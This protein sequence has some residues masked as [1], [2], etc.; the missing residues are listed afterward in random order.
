MKV[1]ISMCIYVYENSKWGLQHHFIVVRTVLVQSSV[2]EILKE[3]E[4][5]W[6]NDEGMRE[7]ENVLMRR[8]DFILLFLFLFSLLPLLVLLLLNCVFVFL[9]VL[10]N[11]KRLSFR[12]CWRKCFQQIL[13][14]MWANE[15][16]YIP[17][18]VTVSVYTLYGYVC[19]CVCV[20]KGMCFVFSVYA[21]K[22]ML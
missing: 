20:C 19:V 9:C 21:W 14:W 15:W 11:P 6:E 18:C 22:G 8:I 2:V 7:C 12:Q 3:P 10:E 16:V 4:S 13:K 17:M 5:V 1:R